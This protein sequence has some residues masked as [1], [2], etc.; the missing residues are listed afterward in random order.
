[1]IRTRWIGGSREF[2]AAGPYPT[3]QKKQQTRKDSDMTRFTKSPMSKAVLVVAALALG[4]GIVWA[5]SPHF[6]FV[7]AAL[8][9]DGDLDV[10]FKEAGLGTNQLIN[11][12]AEAD[13]TVTCTCVTN[14]GQCPNAA[15]KVTGTVAVDQPATFSSGKNGQ[16]NQTISVALPACPTS[17]QPT[18]GGGQELVLS[19]ITWENIQLTDLTTPV[20]PAPATPSSISATLFTCP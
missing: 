14:S 18:C 7:R 10:S 3:R 6:I 13:A 15:N 5:Q 20:G 12:L 9:S 16:V 2:R 11:Y 17:E 19:A 8:Q 4:A 1:M